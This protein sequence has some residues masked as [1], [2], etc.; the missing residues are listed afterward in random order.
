[1]NKLNNTGKQEVVC[2]PFKVFINY[3][4]ERLQATPGSYPSFYFSTFRKSL[5]A[6]Q[7]L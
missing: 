6:K 5:R 7:L 2:I 3:G 4:S 1:L